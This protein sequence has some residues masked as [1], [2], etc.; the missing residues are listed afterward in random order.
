M[1]LSR[2]LPVA[3]LF[4]ACLLTMLFLPQ[5]AY[6]F[7]S[8][9]FAIEQ[10]CGHMHGGFGALLLTTA[11]IGAIVAA[12]LG[13]IRASTSCLITGVG[14]YTISTMLSF[15]FPEAAKVCV[16]GANGADG[17][18]LA[19]NADGTAD[20]TGD[21]GTGDGLT[22]AGDLTDNSNAGGQRFFSTALAIAAG[23]TADFSKAARFTHGDD[24]DEHT[25]DHLE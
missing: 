10:L 15:Y 8:V 19:D 23:R 9:K 14:A 21:T 24:T 4:T 12:A 1:H 11:G 2:V 22:D 3:C 7:E 16:N 17:G 18:A 6:A 25:D 20:G 13:N 5:P